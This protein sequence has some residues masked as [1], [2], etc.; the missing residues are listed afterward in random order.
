MSSHDPCNFYCLQ[1]IDDTM[2][3]RQLPNGNYEVGVHIADVTHFVK[4]DSPL[5]IEAR[6]RVSLEN[7]PQ[8]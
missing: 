8:T 4:Q 6:A 5:D 2:S 1:D 7:P 3:C